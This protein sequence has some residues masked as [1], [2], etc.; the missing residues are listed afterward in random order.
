LKK[1]KKT[2]TTTTTTT[3]EEEEE[4]EA[5]N[6]LCTKLLEENIFLD[7]RLFGCG[8]QEHVICHDEHVIILELDLGT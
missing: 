1:K 5:H 4:E 2:I 3:K 8:L 7:L 6:T